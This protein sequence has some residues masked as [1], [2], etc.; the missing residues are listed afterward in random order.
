MS[1]IIDYSAGVPSAA[2]VK[3]AGHVGA[4]RYV[5]QPREAWMRGKPIGKNELDDFYRNGLSIA[6][7]YQYGKEH[8]SDIKRGYAGGVSDATA[9]LQHLQSLGRG[10]AAC[11]FAVD[12]NISLSEWNDFGVE[13]FRGVNDILGV[14]R[15]GIYG[16]SRIISWAVEDGVIADCGEGH[17]LAWQ[18]AAWSGGEL[19][20]EAV[21]F[22]KI[23]TVTVGGVQCDV[24]EILW[25]EWGQTNASG[26]PHTQ[27]TQPMTE[28]MP[29]TEEHMEADIMPIQPNPNHYGDPLFMPEVLRAF[30]VDVQE[31]DGWREWGMGD[32]TKIWGVAV[33]HTGANNTSAEYIARNPGLENGLSSQIHLS[34]TPPY[35]ATICGAG[36]AWHLGRGS[37]P[38]LPTDNAN[39]YM[40]GIEPQS[41]GVS[42]WPD[43]ML[44]TYHRIVAALLWYLGL[45]SSRCI[46]HW[47][48]SYYAQGKWDPGAGDGVPGHMMDMDEFRANVQKYIDNPPFGKGELMGVLD[49][50]FKSRVP[51][52]EWEGTLR[53]FIINT[54]A[55]AFMGMESAQRNGDKLDKLI[56][57]IEKQNDLLQNIVNRIR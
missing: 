47:E 36:V 44:D 23:G 11:F 27:L 21:L 48:Y 37:Y 18:T 15:T 3:N 43:N 5:S 55:H 26:T 46:A 14:A 40:I 28:E 2:D 24:N 35:T 33:H 10:D 17:F 25:H 42:P 1:T 32:F 39:P 19:A 13:Y 45:D 51:G 50:R 38:G 49:A 52:S 12:Y 7:V 30:G 20:P 57:L 22:Q 34:R 9:V 56:E 6:F 54:N 53:D 29:D 16:H 41:D 4:V 8:D 31:L